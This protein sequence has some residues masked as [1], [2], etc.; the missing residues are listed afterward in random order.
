MMMMMMMMMMVI[1]VIVNNNKSL[2]KTIKYAGNA[3]TLSPSKW[4]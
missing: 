1:I 2:I 3:K 4:K